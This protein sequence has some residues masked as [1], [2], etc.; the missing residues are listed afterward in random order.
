MLCTVCYVFIHKNGP[1]DIFNNLALTEGETTVP[2]VSWLR[3]SGSQL[4]SSSLIDLV[5]YFVAQFTHQLV[6]REKM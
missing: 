2:R 3:F 5:D 4:L 6:R 1:L